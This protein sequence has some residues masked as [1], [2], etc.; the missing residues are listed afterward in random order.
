MVSGRR[1]PKM[2]MKNPHRIRLLV[3]LNLA[4]Y[5]LVGIFYGYWKLK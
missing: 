4:E 1:L 5:L 2:I 3:A